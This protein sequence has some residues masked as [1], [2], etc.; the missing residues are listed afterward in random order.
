MTDQESQKEQSPDTATCPYCAHTFVLGGLK[1]Y[2]Y[3][4]ACGKKFCP[5]SILEDTINIPAPKGNVISDCDFED[6]EPSQPVVDEEGEAVSFGDYEILSEIARGGMGVVYKTRHKLLKRIVALKVLR[7]GEGASEEDIRRFMQEA[8]SAASL[9]HPNIVQIHELNV[10]RGQH[11]FTMDY[12]EGTPLDRL[13]E[14]GPLLPYQACEYMQIISSAISYAHKSGIIHRDIKPANVIIN[15]E[16]QPMITDFGLAVNLST[17]RES[18]RMTRTGAVMG[19]I[20]YIPPEQAS[21]N[22]EQ[23]GPRSD[24]YS[25]GALFYEMLTGRAPFTGLTQYELLQRVINHYPVLPS[26]IIPRLNRDVETICM[27]CL[28]KEP[29][30]RYQSAEQLADDCQAFLHGE[31]IKAR[32]ATMLYRMRRAITRHPEFSILGGIVVLLGLLLMVF[33][34]YARGTAKELTKKTKQHEKVNAD[35]ERLDAMIKRSWRNEYELKLGNQPKVD[36]SRTRAK[37]N[38]FGWYS[39]IYT[40]ISKDAITISSQ[41]NGR[42]VSA[43]AAPV[44]LPFDFILESKISLPKKSSKSEKSKT[45]GSPQFLIGVDDVFSPNEFTRIIELGV[46]GAP[47]A[48]ILSNG[49]IVAENGTFALAPGKDYTVTIVRST[50]PQLLR[51]FVD[52]EE[53]LSFDGTVESEDSEESYV[54]L[55]ALNGKYNLKSFE[56]KVRGMSRDM[57]INNLETADGFSA[58]DDE[59]S[60]AR[61]LYEKVLREPAPETILLR[62]Y[63][64]YIKTLKQKSDTIILDCKN[65]IESIRQSR[66]KQM[67]PG[68]GD[69]FIGL[70]LLKNYPKKSLRYFESASNRALASAKRLVKPDSAEISGSVDI[71]TTPVGELLWSDIAAGKDGI[72][73]YDLVDKFAK[74]YYYLRLQFSASSVKNIEV[75][76]PQDCTLWVNDIEPVSVTND[77]GRKI[78]Y[79]SATFLAGNNTVLMQISPK[80]PKGSVFLH[81]QE[82]GLAFASVYGLLA[83]LD[84]AL[85]L[86]EMGKTEQAVEKIGT[87]QRDGTLETLRD[88]Y[89]EEIQARGVIPWMLKSADEMLADSKK[90][91]Y[92]WNLLEAIRAINNDVYNKELALRY[93]NLA[94]LLIESNRL[95]LAEELLGQ[96]VVLAPDWHLPLL[97]NAILLYRQKEKWQQG[98]RAFDASLQ[99]LPESLELRLAIAEF[100]LNPSAELAPNPRRVINPVPIRALKAAEEAVELSER[101]SPLALE[102]CARAKWLLSKPDDALKYIQEAILLENTSERQEFNEMVTRESQKVSRES[103]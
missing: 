70:A 102:Y 81:V 44:R 89:S 84:S 33:V 45:P 46:E 86:L 11:Y 22:L 100:F 74:G 35:K 6:V 16:G 2:I 43:F 92:A 3:C 80:L 59:R 30:R 61:V 68:E 82:K 52:N 60:I 73:R 78:Q 34:G 53:V 57:I 91:R 17:D 1:G 85:A 94:Q 50:K 41:R 9:V 69:Y 8:K 47:G 5:S 39:N 67:Q 28:D 96:A 54:A 40:R 4:L 24:V 21:G 37:K 83:R 55:G 31:I 29:T 56:V 23:V 66:S 14:D 77:K 27:K 71:D 101:K 42:L 12:V 10:H 99:A 93:Y 15:K 7:A 62:A 64:G 103:K 58:D 65:M 48:K 36:T 19:T 20:P 18:Q 75:S 76:Y 63:T 87:L 38:S 32:P 49:T 97:Q 98:A 26:K 95:Q 90:V 25:L 72:Y 51:V 79:A 13:L 88:Q